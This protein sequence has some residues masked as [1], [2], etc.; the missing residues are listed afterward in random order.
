[1]FKVIAS[2]E[3]SEEL[4]K[5][6]QRAN[7]GDWESVNL[8]K[9]IEKGIKNYLA[10]DER[11]MRMLV[12]K[13]ENL[14]KIFEDRLHTNI[15][16]NY[17]NQNFDYFKGFKDKD[18]FVLFEKITRDKNGVT[19]TLPDGT[20]ESISFTDANGKPRTQE[21]F[22]RCYGC[23]TC[24]CDISRVTIRCCIFAQKTKPTII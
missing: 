20:K 13:P 21:D 3:F 6:R 2:Q 8:V 14:K 17:N 5:L 23:H 7:K 16:I 12:E 11:T 10:I 1:M 24:F 22:I 15:K 9:L 19:V 4:E 18:G